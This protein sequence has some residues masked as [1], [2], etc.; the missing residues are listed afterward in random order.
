M[1]YTCRASQA[2]FGL[3]VK[4]EGNQK[5]LYAAEFS[6]KGEN[7]DKYEILINIVDQLMCEAPSGYKRYYPNPSNIEKVDQARARAFIH[8]FLKVKYGINDFLE[9]EEY[10]TDEVND[11]GI[12]AYY[13]DKDSKT[14]LFIQS[15]Y[16]R[17]KK[18]F[19]NKSIEIDEILKMDTDRILD[20]ETEDE[21]GVSYNSK[22]KKMSQTISSID[23]IGRY[24]YRVIILANIKK[25]K[26]KPSQIKKLS[27]GFPVEVFNYERCY[28]ELVFP[29]VTG[30]YYSADEIK[31]RLSLTN[32]E[33]NDGRISYTVQTKYGACKI[34]V[35]FVPVL[36]IAKVVAKYK[37][38]ILKFNPRCFLSLN[39][40]TINPKIKS[41][42]KDKITNEIALYNNG[43][44]ILSDDTDFS[45]KV[46]IKDTAQLVIKNPQIVNGGQTA[47]T[48]ASIYEDDPDYIEYFDG[49]EVLVKI[50]TFLGE[51]K[52]KDKLLLIEELSRATNEQTPVKEVDRRANDRIQIEYQQN[53]YRDFGYFYNR[54]MGEFYDGLNHNFITRDKIVD[55][56][57]FM[58]VASSIQGEIAK[59]RRNGDEFLFKSEHF[60]QIFLDTNIYR[61]YMYGYFCHLYLTELEKNFAK[62]KNNKFGI[63]TFGNALRYGKYAVTYVVSQYYL[64]T[65]ELDEYTKNARMYTDMILGQWLNFEKYATKKTHNGDYFYQVTGENG[66]K[67]YYYNYDGYYKGRTING[68]LKKYN[69][70][71]N[72]NNL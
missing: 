54:K 47:Y 5:K 31:I 35:A 3:P 36:E 22:I 24:G 61:K 44:T 59:A 56:T 4:I 26:Y 14:I 58:R 7:M 17:N 55:R 60:N 48:I 43:I 6:D 64:D 1:I 33:N 34:M 12:D 15:K 21:D 46:A 41:T 71:I 50:I 39:N 37:N 52:E 16:R 70:I 65:I 40:N 66:Q 25:E 2:L 51:Y 53:I 13:I 62:T 20:G 72:P 57:V 49:K 30:C 27:G 68:D 29:V 45:S 42:I 9:R 18:N 8:L 28:N 32:K 10:I 67:E 69:F 11:G 23:D 19:E 63:N 38:S